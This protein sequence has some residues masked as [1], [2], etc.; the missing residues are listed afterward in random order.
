MSMQVYRDVILEGEVAKWLTRGDQFVLEE[1]GD[2]GHGGGNSG[3]R[4]IVKAW[5]E[6]H[7]LKHFLIPLD[8][9][10]YHQ[11]RTA[12]AQSSSMSRRIF[13]LVRT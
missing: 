6:E 7:G 13:A 12:G 4:N 9:Q 5:K 11:L 10:I 8:R 3:K 1:D 2:S